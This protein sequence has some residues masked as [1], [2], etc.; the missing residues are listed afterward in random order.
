MNSLLWY[1]AGVLTPV[2]I[3]VAV[4]TVK[5]IKGGKVSGQN[6]RE[7]IKENIVVAKGD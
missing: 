4:A 6:S 2:L 7:P 3:I 1:L 5:V